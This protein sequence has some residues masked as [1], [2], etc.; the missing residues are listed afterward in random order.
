MYEA[1][2]DGGLTTPIPAGGQHQQILPQREIGTLTA[3]FIADVYV[4]EDEP[5]EKKRYTVERDGKVMTVVYQPGRG[6]MDEQTADNSLFYGW[7][8]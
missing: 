7:G 8:N 3:T 1:R 2:Q 6:W 4:N 5:D